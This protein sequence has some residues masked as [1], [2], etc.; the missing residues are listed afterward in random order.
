MTARV[1]AAFFAS[2]GLNAG[3]AGRDRLRARQGHGAG[4]ERPQE[5][6]ERDRLESSSPAGR[7]A[8]GVRACPRRGRRSGTTPTAIISSADPT[9]R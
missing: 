2:G 7:V 8:S 4:R 1:V 9:N 5:E 6:Q 3:H